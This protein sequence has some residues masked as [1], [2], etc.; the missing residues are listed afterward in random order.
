MKEIGFSIHFIYIVIEICEKAEV[1]DSKSCGGEESGPVAPF[2]V[3]RDERGIQVGSQCRCNKTASKRR[4]RRRLG[5][6]DGGTKRI[7]KGRR[8]R[9]ASGGR[10]RRTKFLAGKWTSLLRWWRRRQRLRV[11]SRKQKMKIWSHLFSHRNERSAQR[12]RE[13]REPHTLWKFHFIFLK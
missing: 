8:V 12:E 3:R 5:F 7:R 11:G 4:R 2:V 6:D 1:P 10:E 13:R 9:C